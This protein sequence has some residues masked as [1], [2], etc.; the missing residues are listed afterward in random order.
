[1]R[2]DIDF[3]PLDKEYAQALATWKDGEGDEDWVDR[4]EYGATVYVNGERYGVVTLTPYDGFVEIDGYTAYRGRFVMAVSQRVLDAAVNLAKER[5]P[6]WPVVVLIDD[7]DL[8][9]KQLCGSMG[10]GKVD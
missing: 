4:V 2:F 1:M 3:K 5:Y 8:R 9:V 7:K 6:D 10:F